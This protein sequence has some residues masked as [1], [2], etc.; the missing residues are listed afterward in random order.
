MSTGSPVLKRLAPITLGLA[1]FLVSA[2]TLFGT[3]VIHIKTDR[4]VM[5][6]ADKRVK[7]LLPEPGYSDG[8][9]KLI[10]YGNG[11]VYAL[12]GEG[13]TFWNDPQTELKFSAYAEIEDF[14][15]GRGADDETIEL[16]ELGRA[17]ADSMITSMRQAW[18][19][20][21]GPILNIVIAHRDR[22][23]HLRT[24]RCRIETRLNAANVMT[25]T[26]V[27]CRDTT[28]DLT[29]AYGDG[30]F[31]RQLYDNQN[32][33]FEQYRDMPPIRAV[34]PKIQSQSA[35]PIR[36]AD[37]IAFAE[38]V[39]RLSSIH[40][41]NAKADISEQCDCILLS[42]HGLLWDRKPGGAYPP[43]HPSNPNA[44]QPK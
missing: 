32:T 39:I 10:P 37:A 29:R 15:R 44:P 31:L 11:T 17:V 27:D 6:C 24:G 3:L 25:S 7:G 42:Q 18:V 16:N 22:D 4:G 9:I 41:R 20:P 14:L 21:P 2:S 38:T 36:Y 1:I 13:G 8:F 43:G 23:R 12:T 19:D 28:S 34:L 35:V 40:V 5:I 33:A 26:T 30:V